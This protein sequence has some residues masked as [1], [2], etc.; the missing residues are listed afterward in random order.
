MVTP[1]SLIQSPKTIQNKP[2]IGSQVYDYFPLATKAKV[3]QV[4]SPK[5]LLPPIRL[6]SNVFDFNLSTNNRRQ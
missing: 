3:E 2:F 1:V 5:T 4:Y 6:N